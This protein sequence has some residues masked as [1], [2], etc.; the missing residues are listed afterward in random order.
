MMAGRKCLCNALVAN[1]GMP[2]LRAA[3]YREPTLV[4]MGNDLVGLDRFLVAGQQGYAA[5]DV[6]EHILAGA[7]AEAIA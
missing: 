7:R 5:A 4:T 1:I 2:Q 3:G 6:V